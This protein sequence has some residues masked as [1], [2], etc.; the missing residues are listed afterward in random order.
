[1][2]EVVA[3]ALKKP[4]IAPPGKKQKDYSGGEE[5][6]R[7][8]STVG[9]SLHI[10]ATVCFS[11]T[12]HLSCNQ[13]QSSLREKARCLP[14]MRV[15]HVHLALQGWIMTEHMTSVWCVQSRYWFERLIY[16]LKMH[17]HDNPL[18]E[19]ELYV[20]DTC[21]FQINLKS[22]SQLLS[23]LEIKF[24]VHNRCMIMLP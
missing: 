5:K 16:W 7:R 20:H 3:L 13:F 19:V 23:R 15:I 17:M 6:E 12:T 2:W 4:A 22:L 11:G 1:M 10:R 8:Q 14:G 9:H 21:A 24:V 18:M